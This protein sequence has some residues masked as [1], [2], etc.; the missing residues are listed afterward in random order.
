[1]RKPPCWSLSTKR[2]KLT[3]AYDGTDFS[4][5]AAQAGRRTVQGTLKD[6]VRQISGED[7]E[8]VGASRTDGG[9]HARGQVCHF[10]LVA[11]IPIERIP[12]VL[13]R[14]L[15][16]D[17]RVQAARVVPESFHSR[18]CAQDR[19][20]RY[21][22][23]EQDRNPF[24]LR[25]AFGQRHALDL[26][27]MREAAGQ[28]VGTHDFRA[29]TE[30]LEPHVENT[31]RRLFGIKLTRVKD[32][33]RID[34]VGTAFLRGMM[35]RISGYL[36]EVGVHRRPLAHGV[37]LLGTERNSLDWPVVLP[38]RGLTLMAVRYGR[39]PRDCRLRNNESSAQA[40]YEHEQNDDS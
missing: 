28:L 18:F 8:I 9:A 19:W 13:N 11:P 39:H 34:I 15:P 36:Y 37:L 25:M 20:Y 21:V 10:D 40:D 24:E 17:V 33:V 22:I 3:V 23:T 38:A 7:C 6:A 5:W 31:V 30:E 32:Q 14:A 12:N 4:G 2:I 16:Q 27:L 1:M 35:R 29:F 26:E